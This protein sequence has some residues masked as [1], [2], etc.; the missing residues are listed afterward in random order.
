MANNF[1]Q[2]LFQGEPQTVFDKY[3][4]TANDL[5]SLRKQRIA[6][7]L[8][9]IKLQYAPQMAQQG[10]DLG[11]ANVSIKQNEA[12]YAPQMSLADL[13]QKHAQTIYENAETAKSKLM[14]QG[15]ALDNITKRA[16]AK[17]APQTVLNKLKLQQAQIAM[18]YAK[19]DAA[20]KA[21]SQK[22]MQIGYDPTTG[23]QVQFPKQDYSIPQPPS[24]QGGKNTPP[25]MAA[26][27]GINLQQSNA[28]ST[29]SPN[30]FLP[31]GPS[32]A[33][34]VPSAL[35]NPATKESLSVM[36]PQQRSQVQNQVYSANQALELLPAI[37]AYGTTGKFQATGMS[38]YF[39][40]W[41]G[42]ASFDDAAKYEM[43]R[44]LG[45]ENLMTATKL[46]KTDETI[47]MMKTVVSR[48][49]GESRKG[50]SQ[51]IDAFTNKLHSLINERNRDLRLG[52]IPVNDND[53]SASEQFLMNEYNKA[54]A[55]GSGDKNKSSM[56]S[57]IRPD[58]KSGKLDASEVQDALKNG[59]KL[60]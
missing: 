25:P 60:K 52:A 57:V 33:R 12:K 23:L 40:Q 41:I 21:A 43:V 45:I 32:S 28:P 9:Q 55:A 29:N 53:N 27:Q 20:S 47:N 11:A 37:K 46:N 8:D 38:K 58:G 26:Q 39:P 14:S 18:T 36:S 19:A 3:A 2:G 13:A 56:I 59:W 17:N 22:N 42:G 7:A 50:Y 34:G 15:I 30:L 10:A 1:L 51:R 44:N 6:N 49:N 24:L 31:A 35:Y 4:Q 16:E 5:N 48:Q 54:K